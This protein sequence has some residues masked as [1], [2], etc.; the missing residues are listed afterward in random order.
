MPEKASWVGYIARWISKVKTAQEPV[1]TGLQRPQ[2]RR[3][4]H[5]DYFTRINYV[6]AALRAARAPPRG[7]A[8]PSGAPAG[9][10]S[11]EA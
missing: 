8:H 2:V 7:T 5:S 4:L 3:L 10:T 1:W 9:L 11:P 6:L